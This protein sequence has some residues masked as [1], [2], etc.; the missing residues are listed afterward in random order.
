MVALLFMLIVSA[1]ADP[2]ASGSAGADAAGGPWATQAA[3][4]WRGASVAMA[5]L[6]PEAIEVLALIAAGGPFPYRQ[7]GAAFQ[8]REGLLPGRQQGAYREYTVET[9]GSSDRG[10]RRLVVEAGSVLYYTDDHYDSFRFVE[11]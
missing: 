10:A 3:S 5:D 11:P 4:D 1:C 2:D 7:D 9:P 8:N 6:P